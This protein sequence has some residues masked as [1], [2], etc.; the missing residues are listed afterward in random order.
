MVFDDTL[1]I[2]NAPYKP[3]KKYE[4][5]WSPVHYYVYTCTRTASGGCSYYAPR[6]WRTTS[7]PLQAKTKENGQDAKD[8][9]LG[10]RNLGPCSHS[11]QW[12]HHVTHYTIITPPSHHYHE[13]EKR[14]WKDEMTLEQVVPGRVHFESWITELCFR[15]NRNNL[16]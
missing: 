10:T 1:I 11:S 12:F 8:S 16:A 3:H 14:Q 15:C 6:N 5:Q 4:K 2:N 9:F 13:K 7:Y